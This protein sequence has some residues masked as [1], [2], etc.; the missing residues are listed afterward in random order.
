MINSFPFFSI[1]MPVYN[2]E[3]YL[4]ASLDSILNQTFID[5]EVICINDGS[6]DSSLSI[7]EEY[8]IKSTKIHII[9]QLNNG[10][11]ASRNK[12]IQESRGDYIFFLDS[13]DW[14]VPDTLKLLFEKQSGEDMICFNGHRYFENGTTEEPDCGIEEKELTGWEY[15]NKYA[16]IYRKFHFVCTVL[17]IYRRDFLLQYKLFFKEGIF[18]E[19]NL[20]TPIACYYAKVIKVIP[21][22]LYV[23][24]IRQGSITQTTNPK[25]FIDIILVANFLSNFFIPINGIDKNVIYREISGEYFKCFIP[26]QLGNCVIERN[27]LKKRIN[28]EYFKI[29]SIYPRHK[30]IYSL[31]KIH[32]RL[33]IFYLAIEEKMRAKYR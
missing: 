20:F 21:D 24:R 19:D 32:F 12:G 10:L 2:V 8:S 15:Y 17:R 25:R 3:N 14:I 30:R 4:R 18:H 13:D 26:E 31:L 6:T 22:C 9:D 16:L 28:W 1:V 5:Y 27:E 7:L 11:S 33:F 23:Y 29:V